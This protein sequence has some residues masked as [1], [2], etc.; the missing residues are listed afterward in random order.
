MHNDF[1]T[2]L[3][4]NTQEIFI[5]VEACE[6]KMINF[7]SEYNSKYHASINLD[8]NGIC[9]LG[10]V[11]KWGVE[12]RIYFNDTRGISA[13]WNSRKYLNKKYRSDEFQYRLD[14]NSLARYLF[15][16]GYVIGCN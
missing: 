5:E 1:L 15:D 3:Q 11:D 9:L 12:L 8:S 7:I 2:F 10:D 16:N 4:T 14:D 13:Y 6:D